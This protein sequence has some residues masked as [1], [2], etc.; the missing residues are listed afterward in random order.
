MT[1]G[2][3]Y[4]PHSPPITTAS[5]QQDLGFRMVAPAHESGGANVKP[6]QSTK[7]Q[8][9]LMD[10]DKLLRSGTSSSKDLPDVRPTVTF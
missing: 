1:P 3:D 10:L 8:W 5:G 9:N 6:V 7:T 4:V 2:Y